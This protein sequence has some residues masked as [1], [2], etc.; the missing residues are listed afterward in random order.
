VYTTE[1]GM[2]SK[3]FTAYFSAEY[4]ERKT[5]RRNL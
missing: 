1:K 2:V 4:L 3:A 5:Q